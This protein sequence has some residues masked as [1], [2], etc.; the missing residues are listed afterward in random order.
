MLDFIIK[1][2]QKLAYKE[3]TKKDGH[4]VGCGDRSPEYTKAMEELGK[5]FNELLDRANRTNKFVRKPELWLQKVFKNVC[6]LH[7]SGLELE[8]YENLHGI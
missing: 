5:Y 2:D 1:E 3:G 4:A 8:D 6:L 7:K